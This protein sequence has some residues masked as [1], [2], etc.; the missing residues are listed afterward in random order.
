MKTSAIVVLTLIFIVSAADAFAQAGAANVIKSRAR[1]TAGRPAPAK[2]GAPPAAGDAAR[3]TSRTAS[4]PVSRA[5]SPQQL[6]ESDLSLI[7]IK[8]GVTDELR[9]RLAGHIMEGAGEGVKPDE[10][11]IRKLAFDVATA[12]QQHKNEIGY[13]ERKKLAE[14]LVQA[15]AGSGGEAA[16]T[17]YGELESGLVEA[18][19]SKTEV[20]QL[21]AGIKGLAPKTAN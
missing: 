6:I 19:L 11:A 15:V 18:G 2:N 4:P 16:T 7:R 8:R 21:L 20:G 10:A 13:G 5:R 3:T 14:A 12:V 17:A 9:D 1:S